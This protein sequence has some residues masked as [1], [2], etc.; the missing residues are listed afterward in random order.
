MT[1]LVTVDWLKRKLS[2]DSLVLLYTR[3]ANISTGE[4]EPFENKVI[5][6][7]RLFDF[8]NE[9]CDRTSALPHTTLH[10]LY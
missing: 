5:L 3:L 1:A 10:T 4:I 7:A 6:G 8:E 9:F 2:S